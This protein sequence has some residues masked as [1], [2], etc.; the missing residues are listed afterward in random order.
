VYAQ[1]NTFFLDVSMCVS[2]G[3][4]FVCLLEAT[5]G[6]QC[7]IFV[8]VGGLQGTDGKT[9][10]K[11][12]SHSVGYVGGGRRGDLHVTVEK[13]PGQKYSKNPLVLYP[14]Y[15]CMFNKDASTFTA[16]V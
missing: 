5:G 2:L 13:N 15:Y 9:V 4:K 8:H 16:L 11:T 3:K 10:I 6:G 12:N 14:A 1:K 7:C